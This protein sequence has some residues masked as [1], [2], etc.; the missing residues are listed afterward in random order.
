MTVARK[1]MTTAQRMAIIMNQNQRKMY[2]FSFTM[3]R[4]R[5]QMASCF[6]IV[7]EGPNLRVFAKSH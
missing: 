2:V 1:I 3:L 5:M 6:S 4:G 7:A